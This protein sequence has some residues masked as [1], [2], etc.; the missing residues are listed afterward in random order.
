MLQYLLMTSMGRLLLQ[1][2]TAI[3]AFERLQPSLG[4]LVDIIQDR[5]PFLWRLLV[6]FLRSE[7]LDVS[8]EKTPPTFHYIIP[9][10]TQ[11]TRVFFVA[12][13]CEAAGNQRDLL[14]NRLYAPR[15]VGGMYVAESGLLSLKCI[16][17]PVTS[18]TLPKAL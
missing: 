18:H 13:F 6:A 14:R 3:L 8:H 11:P 5:F 12:H 17:G 9:Y 2:S 4:C 15:F 16:N 10:I 7:G 1:A